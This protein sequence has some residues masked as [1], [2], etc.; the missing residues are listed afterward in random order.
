MSRAQQD[1][2]SISMSQTN[3][4]CHRPTRLYRLLAGYPCAA[5]KIWFNFLRLKLHILLLPPFRNQR[6]ETYRVTICSFGYFISSPTCR[7][8]PDSACGLAFPIQTLLHL[9][10]ASYAW[11]NI[12]YLKQ[13]PHP[14]PKLEISF[15]SP[16]ILMFVLKQK[17][18]QRKINLSLR[19][20]FTNLFFDRSGYG[21]E[22]TKLKGSLILNNTFYTRL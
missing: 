7:L 4:R 22:F 6:I 8:S 17:H 9:P 1:N 12:G 20:D 11:I 18:L 21:N 15:I 3:I 16:L 10:V 2:D 19:K 5:T 13:A 14:H